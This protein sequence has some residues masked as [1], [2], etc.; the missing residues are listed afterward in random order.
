MFWGTKD[1]KNIHT[2]HQASFLHHFQFQRQKTRKRQKNIHTLHHLGYLLCSFVLVLLIRK[3]IRPNV[4][5]FCTS[6]VDTQSHKAECYVV[7]Y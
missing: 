6:S 7:L 2:L 4:M 3:A 1:K 5:N